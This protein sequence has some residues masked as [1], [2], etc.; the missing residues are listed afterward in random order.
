MHLGFAELRRPCDSKQLAACAGGA[1]SPGEGSGRLACSRFFRL[2]RLMHSLGEGGA[3]LVAWLVGCTRRTDSKRL[4]AR[5][6]FAR[7][8]GEGSKRLACTTPSD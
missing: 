7:S 2:Q 5:A 1:H 6:G 8:P 4:V 3:R